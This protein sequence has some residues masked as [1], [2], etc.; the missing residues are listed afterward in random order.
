MLTL[1]ITIVI[2]IAASAVV[3]LLSKHLSEKASKIKDA[4]TATIK[5]EIYHCDQAT[6]KALSKLNT[7]V[8]LNDKIE[9]EQVIND[10]EFAIET[11]QARLTKIQ[12]KLNTLKAE[13]ARQEEKIAQLKKGKDESFRMAEEVRSKSEALETERNRL[14]A[15]LNN[16]KDQMIALKSELEL[17]STQAS[18]I[19]EIYKSIDEASARLVELADSHQIASERFLNL[20]IQYEELEK[21]YSKLI[22]KELNPD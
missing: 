20:Q 7:M 1:I 4:D 3:L 5:N 16:S 6:K 19:D 9:V 13:V 22:A 8:S 17:T 18:A 15:E 11:E 12:D 10:Q 2:L 14:E 21:E